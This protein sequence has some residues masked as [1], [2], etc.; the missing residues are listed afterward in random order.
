M[1]TTRKTARGAIEV[2][3]YASLPYEA[4]PEGPALNELHV[5]EV[6]TGGV[7]GQ[8]VARMLQALGKDGAA[9]FCAI[10]RVDGTL[11]GRRGTFVLQDSGTLAGTTVK[12]A[13]FVVPGSGTGELVGL[14]GEGTFEA[15]LGAHASYVLDHWFE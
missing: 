14:R 7:V 8:G 5:T 1:T 6:F 15:E 9:S 2:K 10:E 4:P 3:A 11:D 13:W 12:G